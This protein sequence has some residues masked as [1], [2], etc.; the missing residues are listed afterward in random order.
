[1]RRLLSKSDLQSLGLL[2]A[3]V[4][5]STTLPLS[6]GTILVS[7]HG[8]PEITENICQPLQTFN[9]VLN[10]LLARPAP[11]VPEFVLCALGLALIRETTRRVD[12]RETP[13][14]PP[15]KLA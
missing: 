3:L 12:Y 15:P 2:M 14:T 9:L 4:V 6:V 8:Q 11:A 1:M 13:D 10:T 7:D 5:L